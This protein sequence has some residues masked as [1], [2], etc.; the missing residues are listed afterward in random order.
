MSLSMIELAMQILSCSQKELASKL[1][2]SPTQITKW[3]KGEYMSF[4]ME[5]KV[6]KLLDIGDLDPNVI[7]AFGHISHAQKWQKIITQLA[8]SAND[9]GE[10]GFKVAPLID[11]ADFVLSNLVDSLRMIGYKFPLSFP[12]ELENDY[13]HYIDW[14]DSFIETI[15][16]NEFCSL[17]YNIFRSFVDVYSFYVAYIS[18]LDTQLLIE[19][20]E[21]SSL[22]IDIEASLLNLA[23][24]KADTE[25]PELRG[26]QKLKREIEKD[27]REWLQQL[28]LYAFKSNI[29]LR[30]ELLHLIDDEHDNLGVEAEA[31][32]LGFNDNRLHPDIYMNELLIGMRLLH[33]VLPVILDK[34]E[35]KDF[36]ID[37]ESLRKF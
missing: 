26:F 34:L 17:I 19:N 16:S 13:D 11:E 10:T 35:I 20:S 1:S 18:E 12:P 2:V 28:K 30:A 31:E 24:I 22:I 29:P 15:Y 37:N 21:F 32:Y 33:Q 23:I 8:K 6:R 36:D 14:S 9:N 27:Y 4:D 5:N 3:K 25:L 7:L